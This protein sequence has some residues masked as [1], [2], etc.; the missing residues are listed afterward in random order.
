M[1]DGVQ[2]FMHVMNDGFPAVETMTAQE[3]RV[4]FV[5]RRIPVGNLDDVASTH[6]R[7][8]PGPEVTWVCASSARAG[9]AVPAPGAP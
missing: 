9:T 2:A 5:G 4:V 6:D 3:A 8:I 1:D 7:L